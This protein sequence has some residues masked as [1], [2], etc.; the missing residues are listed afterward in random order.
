MWLGAWWGWT[1][2]FSLSLGNVQ[3]KAGKAWAPASALGQ[4]DFLLENL[5]HPFV[6]WSFLLEL[7]LFMEGEWKMCGFDAVWNVSPIWTLSLLLFC[8][9]ACLGQPLPWGA[10][11][12]PEGVCC[13]FWMMSEQDL[14]DV[15]QIAVEDLTPDNPGRK[16]FISSS[17][18][19][20]EII[21]GLFFT[22]QTG[23]YSKSCFWNSYP[24]FSIASLVYLNPLDQ[25]ILFVSL[26]SSRL[27]CLGLFFVQG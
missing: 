21:P 5:H 6:G 8:R 27:Y 10:A 19:S 4:G 18:H 7:N 20:L 13:R 11:V 16:R 1:W 14:A 15:V 25:I 24:M 22:I 26:F 17:V 9:G 23:F 12:V 3:G 2:E